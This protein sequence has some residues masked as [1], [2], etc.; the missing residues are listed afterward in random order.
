MDATSKVLNDKLRAN[1]AERKHFLQF[2]LEI[3]YQK[4]HVLHSI[5]YA[6]NATDRLLMFLFLIK[7]VNDCITV[8]EM[9]G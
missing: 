4:L 1:S 6:M 7:L 2:N 3:F 8:G 9:R 5:I